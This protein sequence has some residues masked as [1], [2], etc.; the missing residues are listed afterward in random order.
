MSESPLPGFNVLQ[1]RAGSFYRN[2]D[3][4]GELQHQTHY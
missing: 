3:R 2:F 1:H 4:K